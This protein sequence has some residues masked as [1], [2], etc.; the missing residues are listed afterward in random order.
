VRKMTEKHVDNEILKLLQK[1]SRQSYREI[2]KQLDISHVSV[3]SKVKALEESG[4]I[5]GYTTIT[6]PDKLNSYPLCLRI[7]ASN[8]AD[9]SKIGDKIADYP[10]VSVVMRVSGDC[11]LLALAMSENRESALKLLDEISAIK[12]IGKVESHIVLEAIK[13][14]GVMLKS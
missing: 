2:A 12:G 5:K 8:G 7:S 13:L 1:D 10:E 3:S 14:A 11:E 6:D 4:I 9:L